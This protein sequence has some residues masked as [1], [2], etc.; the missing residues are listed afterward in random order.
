MRT[1]DNY[2]IIFDGTEAQYHRDGELR[3]ILKQIRENLSG[4][5]GDEAY[6]NWNNAKELAEK[7]LRLLGVEWEDEREGGS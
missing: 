1:G 4:D 2:D 3:E 6:I 7:G 5:G